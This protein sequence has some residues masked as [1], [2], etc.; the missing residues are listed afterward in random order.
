MNDIRLIIKYV[1]H[2][3]RLIRTIHTK[4]RIIFHETDGP[5]IISDDPMLSDTIFDDYKHIPFFDPSTFRFNFVPCC[6]NILDPNLSSDVS[7]RIVELDVLEISEFLHII[8]GPG[9]W[10]S[11]SE[12]NCVV[13]MCDN[14]LYYKVMTK[15]YKSIEEKKHQINTIDIVQAFIGVYGS[16]MRSFDLA[17]NELEEDVKSI[18]DSNDCPIRDVCEH[19]ITDSASN[20]ICTNYSCDRYPKEK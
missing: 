7:D 13:R 12:Y 6:I 11:L 17:M 8:I 9:L 10:K 2:H 18:T 3:M 5:S 20:A 15:V 14:N 1:D 16:I 4:G 19:A